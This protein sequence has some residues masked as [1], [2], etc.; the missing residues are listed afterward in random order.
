MKL[1]F[2]M[3]IMFCTALMILASGS[4]LPMEITIFVLVTA[5]ALDFLTTWKCVKRG[6]RE[7]NPMIAFL[8]RKIGVGKTFG[9]VAC[10]WVCFILFRWMPATEGLQTAVAF[11]YWLVPINNLDVLTRLKKKKSPA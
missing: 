11:A 10:V 7:G 9:L 2:F 4:T 8:F 6:G 5:V 1:I 3:T